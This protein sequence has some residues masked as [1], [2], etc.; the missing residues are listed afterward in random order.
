MH[1]YYNVGLN[2]LPMSRVKLP[3]HSVSEFSDLFSFTHR[4]EYYW[5]NVVIVNIGGIFRYTYCT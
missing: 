2:L 5:S 3:M 1:C 4:V